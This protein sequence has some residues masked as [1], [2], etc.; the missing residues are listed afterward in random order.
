[1]KKNLFYFIKFKKTYE[2]KKKINL[3]AYSQSVK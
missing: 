1:M 2:V 3:L